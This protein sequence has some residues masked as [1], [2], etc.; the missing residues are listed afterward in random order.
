M[1][2]QG[3]THSYTRCIVLLLLITRCIKHEIHALVY[4]IATDEIDIKKRDFMSAY[5][6]NA[7]TAVHY[8]WVM[9]NEMKE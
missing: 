2:E 3:N 7:Y 1:A 8:N 9:T 5:M 4:D 6:R